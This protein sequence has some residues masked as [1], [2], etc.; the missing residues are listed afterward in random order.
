MS[1]ARPGTR[2]LPAGRLAAFAGGWTLEAAN[3]VA[4]PNGG[5]LALRRLAEKSFV[6]AED[7]RHEML[8]TIRE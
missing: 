1:R 7:D 2:A 8:E 6:R 5:E 4:V 3:A